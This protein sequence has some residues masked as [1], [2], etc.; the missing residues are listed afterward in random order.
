MGS[1]KTQ[2][3]G[4]RYF[5]G[6]HMG[7]CHGPIDALL[8]IRAGDRT[9]WSGT[10]SA[11]GSISIN[12]P[13][14]FGGEAREG[15]LQGTLDVMM[16]ESTQAANAY[17]TAQQGTPQPAYR[18]ILGL[19]YRSGLVACNNPYV[20]P[21]A[22]RL[23]RILQGWD[24]GTVWNSAQAGIDLG[25]GILAANP[26]HIVYECLTNRA[27][28]MGLSAGRLDLASFAAAAATFYT[29]GM[30]L[31][32]AWNKQD[33]IEG[34]VQQVADHAGASCG[35][36]P[37]TG[38]IRLTAIRDDY[39]IGSLPVFSPEAGNVI[40]IESFERAAV[41]DVKNEITVKYIDQVTGKESSVTIQ[42]LA[43]VQA[44]GGASPAT[45]S[46]PGIP[47][48]SLA[49]RVALRDLKAAT[50]GL[51]RVR[52]TINRE[53]YGLL[54]GDVI[55]FSWADEG[56]DLM[57]LRVGSVDYGSY[58]N[59]AITIEAV[60]DVFGLPATTYLDPQAGGWVE[61]N[62]TPQASAA[63]A[64]F[65]TPY[66]ELARA[67]G[68]SLAA[69]LDP[70]AG[71]LSAVAL[72]APGVSFNYQLDTRTGANTYAQA[73][74]GDWTPSG[75]LTTQIGPTATSATLGVAA[76]LDLVEIGQAALIES[77]IVKVTSIDIN[78]LTVGLA[79]G[80]ED[81]V[82]ATHVSASRIWFFE[83]FAGYDP[84]EWA[85]GE[86]V[87][88]KLRTRTSGGLLA[89]GSSPG[90]S[91]TMAQRAWRP[92][93]PGKLRIN[94]SAYPAT[95][96]ARLAI[97]WAHRDRLLQQDQMIDEAQ[98]SIGPEAGTTY[99]VRI[100]QQP[101]TLLHTASGISGTGYTYDHALNADLRVELES[102]RDGLTS[103]QKH[104]HVI[105]C[106]GATLVANGGFAADTDWTKGTGWTIA[107]GVATK[108]AGTASDLYQA[109]ALVTGATYLID[110]TV[111]GYSAGTVRA[112]L[113]GGTTVNG[114][115]RSA[116]GTFSEDLVAVAGNTEIHL[117]A[118]SA[119]AGNIDNVVVRRVA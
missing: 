68:P 25:S 80:C 28:G 94:G 101:S 31:C 112:S 37:R 108:A 66:R 46:Y 43:S 17:L 55:A 69:D 26:A 16:G 47:T 87:D 83:A 44:Q 115:A 51:A 104:V 5:M 67:L 9:A 54:P 58:T 95:A 64:V 72:R 48:A 77:E 84:T 109:A 92:Y 107:V 93:P 96:F 61:P 41:R 35:E 39:S 118:D 33:A 12:A 45:V 59:G 2:T 89:L 119:F 90:G 18:G 14:L 22:F 78:T 20:K 13:D 56:I 111:S 62:R 24:A 60:Q 40:D 42:H 81:T 65:E 97:T 32:F 27:W 1:G 50:S 106:T 15:G 113:V 102:V 100:Y 73:G 3:V 7:L 36:D 21:W 85:T 110:F 86:T 105:T 34:F 23:R 79:R 29:E 82:A 57:P 52:L 114:T 71:F 63:V 91:V 53:G 116:N 6:L 11:S 19:V 30:G 75:T 88:A 74:D 99:T 8:E 117:V 103:T 4:Y 98:T 38:L 76:D 70:D 49:M 10:Q